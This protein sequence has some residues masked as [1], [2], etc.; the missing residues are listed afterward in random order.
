ML[1][2]KP[3]RIWGMPSIMMRKVRDSKLQLLIGRL[4]KNIQ[5]QLALVQKLKRKV[6]K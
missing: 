2:R 6:H 5:A 1:K 3:H 4:E